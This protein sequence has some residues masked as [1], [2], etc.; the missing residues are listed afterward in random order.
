M[1]VFTRIV[2]NIYEKNY[3]MWE[4]KDIQTKSLQSK[5]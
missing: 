4:H 2:L 5:Q 1:H 3:E